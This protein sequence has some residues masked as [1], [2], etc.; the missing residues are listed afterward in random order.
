[1]LAPIR[2]LTLY[3]PLF[4]STNGAD[5]CLQSVEPRG[6]FL[7]MMFV[8]TSSDISNDTAVPASLALP[9]RLVWS[10]GLEVCSSALTIIERPRPCRLLRPTS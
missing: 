1:M 8:L 10:T 9:V 6:L 4:F 3:I 5:G 2:T 7:P